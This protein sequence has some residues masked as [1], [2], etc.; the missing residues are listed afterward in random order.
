MAHGEVPI[1]CHTSIDPCSTNEDGYTDWDQEGLLQCSG[2]A[3]F[4]ANAMKMPRDPDVA[5]G[6]KDDKIFKLTS[7]FLEHHS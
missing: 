3:R 2:A 6:P 5:H 1:A 4:R 7:E